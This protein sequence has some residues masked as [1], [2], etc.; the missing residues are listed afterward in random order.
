[1]L[2]IGRSLFEPGRAHHLNQALTEIFFE[3]STSKIRSADSYE[4]TTLFKSEKLTPL[5][6]TVNKYNGVVFRAAR[7]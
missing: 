6:T 4:L 2:I 5:T 3:I 1:M 7:P